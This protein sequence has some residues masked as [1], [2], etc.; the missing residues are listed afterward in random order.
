MLEE[1]LEKRHA[2]EGDPAYVLGPIVAI[3]K[4]HLPVLD[5]FQIAVGEG[6]AEDVAAEVVEDLLAAP[7]VLAVH[8]PGR[9]PHAG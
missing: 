8:D 9:G 6:D 5:A 3:A 1:A 4:R 2:W 7:R